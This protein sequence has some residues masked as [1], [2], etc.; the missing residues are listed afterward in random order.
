[1]RTAAISV[2][3]PTHN[4]A[5]YLDLSLASWCGQDFASYEL[6]IVDDGSSD[7]TPEVLDRYRSEL[8][9]VVV[10][11]S[12]R[13]RAAARNKGLARAQGTRIV[14][15]DDDRIVTPGY[16]RAHGE[17]AAPDEV[18]VGWQRGLLVDFRNHGDQPVSP[19]RVAC[20]LRGNPEC[21]TDVLAGGAGTLITAGGL[22]EQE[23][24]LEA[25]RLEDP[26]E[27]YLERI[28]GVYG[29]SL[30][31][32]PLAWAC[33]TT[34]SLS[35]SRELLRD[36]GGFDERFIGWGLEDTELNYR[37]A[38]AGARFRVARAA[39]NYHQNH[40]KDALAKRGEWARNGKLFL[41]THETLEVA[42]YL[43]AETGNLPHLEACQ[44]AS[45]A[46]RLGEC[47]AVAMLRRLAIN[48]AFDIVSHWEA[49]CA[50]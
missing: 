35:A 37:L 8:P 24:D 30:S 22:R 20:L 19:A 27:P 25:L 49:P 18:I 46:A 29:E 36:A 11:V 42:L 50:R 48:S 41:R 38:K 31:D 44:I 1:M 23:V 16:L 17:N 2:V 32:C 33:G 7:A 34:G 28:V 5:R 43:H 15:V 47:P 39:L 21:L 26:W 6:I 12:H 40:P 3:I 10:R 13:G 4:K 14:F 45:Q 9:I